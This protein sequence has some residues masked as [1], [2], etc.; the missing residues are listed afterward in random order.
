MFRTTGRVQIN[1]FEPETGF[2]YAGS[3]LG[4]KTLLSIGGAFDFQDDYKYFAGDVTADLPV[5]GNV[6][7]AQVNVAHWD[8]GDFLPGLIN[9]TAIMAEAGFHISAA[10]LAPIVRFERLMFGDEEAGEQTRLGLGL[11]YFPSGHNLNIKAFYTNLTVEDADHA[12]H[13][14]N[15]QGQLYVF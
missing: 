8:G 11:A 7:T 5:G 9:Q 13:Q 12:A 1:V 4:S 15:L 10:Q 14:F 2:F 6:A 3:Y